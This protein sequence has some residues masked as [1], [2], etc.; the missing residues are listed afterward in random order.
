MRALVMAALLLAASTARADELD[1]SYG[2]GDDLGEAA[3][4]VRVVRAGR[5]ARFTVL[6]T[7]R[8]RGERPDEARLVIIPPPGAVA[9]GLRVQRGGRW[10]AGALLDADRAYDRYS[11]LTGAPAYRRNGPALLAQTTSG[12]LELT[13]F[14]V[15]AGGGEVSVEYRLEAPLCYRA[16][17][18]FTGYPYVASGVLRRPVIT[19]DGADVMTP[20]ALRDRLGLGA[21]DDLCPGI[22]EEEPPER[23][24]VYRERPAGPLA[25]RFAEVAVD[26]DHHLVRLEVDVPPVIEPAPRG[27]R[28]VMVIDGSRSQ[29]DDG[30]AA[31]LDLVRGYARDL[32]DAGIEV[33]VYRRV[34]ERLF[35]RFVPAASLDAELARVPARRLAPGNGSHA[36]VGLAL[37]ELALRGAAGPARVLLFTDDRL[38]DRF[39]LAAALRTAGALPADAILHVIDIDAGGSGDLSWTR[40]DDHDLAPLATARGG[41]AASFS[42]HPDALDTTAAAML[43]LVRPLVIDD[44]ELDGGQEILELPGELHGGDGYR[45]IKL[46]DAPASGWALHGRLWSR[47]VTIP[48][49]SDAAGARELA[50]FAFGDGIAESLPE[51]GARALAVRAGVVSAYTSLLARDP[52]AAPT[53]CPEAWGLGLRGTSSTCICSSY[54]VSSHCGIHGTIG[55]G[56]TL[57]GEPPDRPSLIAEALRPDA[58]RCAGA[59]GLAGIALDVEATGDEI[60]DV[61]VTGAAP[62][63][64]A[65]VA[66]AA[67]QLELASAYF[68]LA[69][70]HYQVAF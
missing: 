4:D 15:G 68:D 19:A 58:A 60:V 20:A 9:R 35:G 42:G 2:G 69:H 3:H 14:P 17:L 62:R 13:V 33:V 47:P 59:A 57:G 28:V 67:W 10:F 41:I 11:A 27:A 56:S 49:R 43:G 50:A 70:Q 38:R 55:H 12:Q 54:S 64:A 61:A 16:G 39:E 32:P 66:E 36:D 6:R 52:A 25:A 44:V 34:A 22:A 24:I 37:A 7:L 46:A 5:V 18:L 1:A 45:A 51:A 63:V 48:L 26:A 40:E 8:N 29:G 31:Q 23:M 53:G 21:D 30:I 65:C